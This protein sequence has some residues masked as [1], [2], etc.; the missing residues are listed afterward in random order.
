VTTRA[1]AAAAREPGRLAVVADYVRLTKPRIISL[2]LVTTLCAMLVA[3]GGMPDG[4]LVVWT[5]VGGYLSAGG[6]NAINHYVDRDIDARMRRTTERPVV[7]GRVAPARALAFGITLGAAST[8]LLGLAANWLAAGLALLG[9]VL[10]VFLY[11]LWLKR[12]TTHNIVIGGAAGAVPPLVGWAAVTGDLSLGAL[13]MFAIVF[14]WTPPHFWALALVLRRD[15]AAAGVPM[16]P[17][18]RGEAET[19]RQV[20]LWTLVMVGVS[21]LPT[22]AGVSGLVYLVAACALGVAF[23][24]PAWLLYRRGGERW[25]R[26]TFHVSLAYLALLFVALVVDAL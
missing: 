22:A 15:Y 9:L 13:L 21:L 11:T 16:L 20:L 10:Y 18:V 26:V 4:W 25:A 2:L 23:I 7:S 6:A 12:T 19:R 17:V 8:L 24:V 3:A 14:Y 5:M 1:V